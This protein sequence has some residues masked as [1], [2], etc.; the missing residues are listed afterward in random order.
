MPDRTT[1]VIPALNEATVIGAVVR[2]LHACPAL[3]DAGLDD[4]VVV[5]N[6]SDDATAHEAAAAGARVV[7]EPR[8]GY[9]RACRAGVLATDA[10]IVVLMDGDGSDVPEDVARVWSPVQA[11]IADL[12]M[13]SRSSGRVERG[14][15]T[16]QQRAGNLIGAQLLR[17][18]YGVQVTDIGPLRAIKRDSLLQMDMR[19]MT[20]GWSAEMLAKAGRLGLRVLEVPV[21]YR[22]RAG[23]R[24]KVAGTVRGTLLA[25]WRILRTIA[26]YTRWQPEPAL[27]RALVIVARAPVPGRAKTRLGKIIGFEPAA[28][29]YDAFL[30]DLAARFSTSGGFDLWWYI[31]ADEDADLPPAFDSRNRLCQPEGDLSARLWHGFQYLRAQGYDQILVLGSDSPH[32]PARWVSQAFDHLATHDVVLGPALDGGYYTVGQ[33]GDPADLFTGI[34]M[35]TATVLAETCARITA[36]RRSVAFLPPAFDVDEA[37]DLDRLRAALLAA[38]SDDADPAPATLA[39]LDRLILPAGVE[40]SGQ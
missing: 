24:S 36:A 27:R 21:G 13:G 2:A 5:D 8:R 30:D 17:A 35:S 7:T 6:G 32:I 33:R 19:E 26:R 16:P 31:D 10:Q 4:I 37:P 22:R 39:Q 23:G 29:L 34:T 11:G 40:E 28:Q 20:Y 14:A 1:I 15:L 9:G 25:S 18:L 38:P 12:A 3:R